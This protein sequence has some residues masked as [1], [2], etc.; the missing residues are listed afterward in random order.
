ALEQRAHAVLAGEWHP[1]RRVLLDT[2]RDRSRDVVPP[3]V[4]PCE[5]RG[6]H[7]VISAKYI[8]SRTDRFAELGV[9]AVGGDDGR[10]HALQLR[11]APLRGDPRDAVMGPPR[12]GARD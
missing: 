1:L 10:E 6:Q 12:L 7:R 4:R 11:R 8:T 3:L 9:D 2:I 5:N